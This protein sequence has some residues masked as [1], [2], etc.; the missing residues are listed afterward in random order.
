MLSK[1]FGVLGLAALMAV[2][3]QASTTFDFTGGGNHTSVSE[4]FSSDGI[5]VTVTAGRFDGSNV[6][7]YMY[8]DAV[9]HYSTGLGVDTGRTDEHYVDGSGNNDLLIFR[10]DKTVA[11]ES[12]SFSHWDVDYSWQCTNWGRYGCYD[13]DLVGYEGDDEFS[14]LTG[15]PWTLLGTNYNPDGFNGDGVAWASLALVPY[16]DQLGVGAHDSN[17]EFKVRSLTVLEITGGVPEPATWL[18]MIMGF[19]LVGIAS[20]RR[21][22][23][24]RA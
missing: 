23:L 19:G 3:A 20:R 12:I 1:A 17:D 13:W 14:L 5:T 10:F 18:M 6:V 16:S 21:S 4:S 9:G 24:V 2:P 7:E 11:L 15:N 22:S 8:T